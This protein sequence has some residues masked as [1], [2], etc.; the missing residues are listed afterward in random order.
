MH[1]IIRPAGDPGRVAPLS[2]RG[3]LVSGAFALTAI[4]CGGNKDTAA[5][6]A[7][8]PLE[9]QNKDSLDYYREKMKKQKRR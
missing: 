1:Q 4:G 2:R 6:K 3:F 8:V 9:V 5:S 7:G